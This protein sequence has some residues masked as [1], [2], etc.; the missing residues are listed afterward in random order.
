MNG[1]PSKEVL[2][3]C[4]EIEGDGS[5][6]GLDEKVYAATEIVALRKLVKEAQAMIGTGLL[7]Q[8]RWHAEAKRRLAKGK[9][10]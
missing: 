10:S 7:E 2:R 1:R 4:T 9:G 3:V 5:R 6:D 8:D